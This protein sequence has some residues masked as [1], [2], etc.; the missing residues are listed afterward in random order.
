VT[1]LDIG[2]RAGRRCTGS[3]RSTRRRHRR[4]ARYRRRRWCLS[5]RP[6]YAGTKGQHP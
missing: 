4:L 3:S 6:A 1:R 5:F 2:G